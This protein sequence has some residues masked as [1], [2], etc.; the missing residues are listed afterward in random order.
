M[1]ADETLEEALRR[2][3]RQE[4]GLEVETFSLFG[5]FSHP[6]RIVAYA[7]GTVMQPVTIAYKVTSNASVGAG[8]S[9]QV[10]LNVPLTVG[11][12]VQ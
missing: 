8:S 4:T 7:D 2:E 5:T 11:W 10:T 12:T 6:S 1:E 3:I 9:S